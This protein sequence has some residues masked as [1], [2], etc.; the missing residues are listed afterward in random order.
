MKTLLSWPCNHDK[1]LTPGL[2]CKTEGK[3][4]YVFSSVQYC[5]PGEFFLV[6]SMVTALLMSI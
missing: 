5:G 2:S 3:H 6:A 1:G 4:S